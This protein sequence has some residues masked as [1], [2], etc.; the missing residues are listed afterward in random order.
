[1]NQ[2]GSLSTD[3]VAMEARQQLLDDL[4]PTAGCTSYKHSTTKLIQSQEEGDQVEIRL[5][6][7]P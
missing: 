6:P 1:M 2:Y 5:S 7:S 4:L 3:G